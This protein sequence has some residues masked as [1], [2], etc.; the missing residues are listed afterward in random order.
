MRGTYAHNFRHKTLLLCLNA[1]KILVLLDS[2]AIRWLRQQT[3]PAATFKIKPKIGGITFELIFVVNVERHI[4]VTEVYGGCKVAG[5]VL[6]L[7][8]AMLK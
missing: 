8:L 2:F 1:S 6:Y 4:C 7:V 3:L 5:V